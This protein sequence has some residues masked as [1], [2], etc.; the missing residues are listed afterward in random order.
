MVRPGHAGV[1]F[2]FTRLMYNTRSTVD[3]ADPSARASEITQ[4]THEIGVR[5]A[6]GAKHS[7]VLRLVVRQGLRLALY[8]AGIGV[9]AAFMLTRYLQSMLFGVKSTDPATFAGVT[10]FRPR[11]QGRLLHSGAPSKQVDPMV[12][13]RYE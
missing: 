7:D 6:L 12:A 13:L 2:D 3:Q 10:V 8:G 5:M 11:S 1:L 4:R 9:V